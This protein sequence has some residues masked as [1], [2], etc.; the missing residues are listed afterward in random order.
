MDINQVIVWIVIGGI[1]GLL[2]DAVIKDIR[3][4]LVGAI[5]V[6]ILGAVIGGWLLGLLN[7]IIVAFIGACLLLLVL[8]A[9][10][11]I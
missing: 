8:R 5:I 6:G 3:I 10:K 4:G 7:L 9:L 2:A 1:A 11:R